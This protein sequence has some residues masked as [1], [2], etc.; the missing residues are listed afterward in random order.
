MAVTSPSSLQPSQDFFDQISRDP[1][2]LFN[3]LKGFVPQEV[4]RR[5]KNTPRGEL[6]FYYAWEKYL[7]NLS[8]RPSWRLVGVEDSQD[9]VQC[10]MMGY[11]HSKETTQS[12][13][14]VYEAVEGYDPTRAS[15]GEA[16]PTICPRC[17]SSFWSSDHG[18]GLPVFRDWNIPEYRENPSECPSSILLSSQDDSG[19]KIEKKMCGHIVSGPYDSKQAAQIARLDEHE[20]A[21]V[22]DQ[23]F[24]VCGHPIG[25]M[26]FYNY[27]HAFVMKPL[28]AENRR[29]LTAKTKGRMNILQMYNCPSCEYLNEASCEESDSDSTDKKEFYECKSCNQRHEVD[30]VTIFTMERDNISLDTPLSDDGKATIGDMLPSSG[31]VDEELANCEMQ[32]QEILASFTEILQSIVDTNVNEAKKRAQDRQLSKIPQLR[33]SLKRAKAHDDQDKIAELEAKLETELEN[34]IKDQNKI[35]YTSNLVEMFKLHYIGDIDGNTVDLR[36]LTERFMFK[37]LPYTVCSDCNH[38]E[39]EQNETGKIERQQS[40]AR[41]TLRKIAE[42]GEVP[43]YDRQKILEMSSEQLFP[44]LGSY[45]HCKD[46]GSANLKYYGPGM[47]NPDEPRIEITPHIFQPA[48]REIR[49]LES[50]IYS[51]KLVC[52]ECNTQN[53]VRPD[54][55][56][57]KLLDHKIS[58]KVVEGEDGERVALREKAEHRCSKCNHSLT[59]EDVIASSNAKDAYSLL[60][61]LRYLVEERN[62]LKAMSQV[63]QAKEERWSSAI[64]SPSQDR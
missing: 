46:C 17:G 52:P 50:Q 36:K 60:M 11:V 14:G 20:V 64:S 31:F 44:E 56:T 23:W 34:G 13:G 15:R 5:I 30:A 63:Q 38:R 55:M 57:G 18:N 28:R 22:R 49:V 54:R 39:F 3:M 27:V 10:M 51:Y 40:E 4:I 26:S 42:Q 32:I 2:L 6:S 45:F 8:S 61:K 41:L 58:K 29:F 24:V 1:S 53:S 7:T 16:R 59:L 21:L 62:N 43:G 35:D 37:S 9:F 19:K 12:Q 33:R 25:L 47:K 48:Q